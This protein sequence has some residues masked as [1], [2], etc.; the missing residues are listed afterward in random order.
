MIKPKLYVHVGAGKAGSSSIQTYMSQSPSVNT[1]NGKKLSYYS[2]GPKRILSGSV[3]SMSANKSQFGYRNNVALSGYDDLS[4]LRDQFNETATKMMSK[5]MNVLVSSEDYISKSE[6]FQEHRLLEG[7]PVDVEVIMYIRPPLDWLNS[8]YWQWGAWTDVTPLRWLKGSLFQV[9]WFQL[10]KQWQKVPGVSKVHVRLATSD[11]ISDLSELLGFDVKGDAK[12]ANSGISE[13]V[14]RFFQ[15]NRKYRRSAHEPHY[16]FL[17]SKHINFKDTKSPWVLDGEMQE[18]VFEKL[19]DE[20]KNLEGVVSD[21]DW[22]RMKQDA[23]WWSNAP[24]LDRFLENP[25]STELAGADRLI[26]QLIDAL[27]L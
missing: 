21:K 16:E 11:V 18:F 12:I 1:H 22:A 8:A 19:A 25:T 7:L 4:V 15:R 3:L 20:Y 5:G 9:K 14:L 13:D 2:F 27:K 10:F 17:L 23:R 26:G 24:Y 6:D